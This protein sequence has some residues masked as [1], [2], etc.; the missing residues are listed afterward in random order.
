MPGI[1]D[2]GTVLEKDIV[3]ALP[4]LRQQGVPYYVHAELVDETTLQVILLK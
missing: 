3:A 4:F 1:D 2:F